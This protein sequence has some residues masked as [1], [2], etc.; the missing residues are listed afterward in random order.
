EHNFATELLDSSIADLPLKDVHAQILSID[1]KV[2]QVIIV[3]VK[4]PR[5]IAYAIVGFEFDRKTLLEL[6]ELI[7]LDVTLMLNN[8][9]L[10]SSFEPQKLDSL[11]LVDSFSQSANLLFSNSDYYHQSVK[12]ADSS[13]VTAILSSSLVNINRDLNRLISAT[14]LIGLIIIVVAIALSRML[15]HRVSNPLNILMG[16]TEKIAGG[17]LK[18]PKLKQNLPIEF[19][20]LYQGFSV[21]GSAI[22]HREAEITFQAEHDILTGLYNRNTILS[23]IS[24]SLVQ[25]KHLVLVA[26]NIKGFKSLNDTIGISNGDAI[27]KE[28]AARLTQYI[29]QLNTQHKA[30]GAA[31]RIGSDQ[32]LLSIT[33]NNIELIS[34]LIESLQASLEQS[35]SVNEIEIN[36]HL[37]YGL[38]NSIQHGTDAERLIRRVSMAVTAADAEHSVVRY[39]QDGEDEAYLYKLNLI[40]E[41]KLALESKEG[42]LFLNYQP[43]LNIRTNQVDKVEALIRWINK[44]GDFVNP[45]LFVG[46]AEQAGLIVTLTRWVILH[47]VKQI[48]VWNKNGHN[49]T[50]SI[51]LS[52]QDIQDSLFVDYLL[53]TIKDYGVSPTQIT[54]ELTER[55]LAENEQLVISRLTHLK[56]LGF[57]ISVD[58]YGIGQSSLA[59]L[60]NLP[61]DELKIDKC[62]ILTLDQNQAD[63]DIVSSTISLGHKLGLRVIAEGVENRPSLDLLNKFNCDYAQGYYLSRPLKA[64]DLIQ[65]YASYEKPN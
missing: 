41:L 28:I 46:L 14:I 12:F 56:S 13:E 38:T 50:V 54:L 1:N 7:A 2:F 25:Q 29:N 4:A 9:I 44:K 45:E 49:F 35:Y 59:K 8:H 10:N 55:D 65:W 26:F 37:Y 42:P 63:Q 23:Q 51:N 31:A 57:E 39:Y 24:N 22:E 17:K 3:P 32:F 34:E 33:I 62:F 64:D 61:V 19:S 58:D 47:V 21:M 40:E 6:K 60:K 20:E 53:D 11:S 5:V 18:V 27:L 48:S 15:S 52:A 16:L 30:Q 43:K 36:L